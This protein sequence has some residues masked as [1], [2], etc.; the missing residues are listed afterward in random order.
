MVGRYQIGSI[1]V[2]ICKKGKPDTDLPDLRP[3]RGL[4]LNHEH[5]LHSPAEIVNCND[6][7]Q[8][9][10]RDI[11]GEA[12]VAVIFCSVI[13]DLFQECKMNRVIDPFSIFVD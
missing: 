3:Y 1:K 11:C 8:I 6:V 2:V 5:G 4:V 9:Y 10:S 12:P 13:K 7:I